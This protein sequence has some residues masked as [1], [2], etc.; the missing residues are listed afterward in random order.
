MQPP[1]RALPIQTRWWMRHTHLTRHSF[2]CASFTSETWSSWLGGK[3]SKLHWQILQILSELRN[4]AY[5]KSKKAFSFM[6]W[7]FH[8]EMHQITPWFEIE[9]VC[10][11]NLFQF[12]MQLVAHSRSCGTAWR[13]KKKAK[14]AQLLLRA[15][16]RLLVELMRFSVDFHYDLIDSTIRNHAI[17]TLARDIVIQAESL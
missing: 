13:W 4:K 17:D 2:A 15:N 7:K 8:N 6:R 3:I 5:S 16:C 11:A 1:H 14:T 9:N 12:I 10:W